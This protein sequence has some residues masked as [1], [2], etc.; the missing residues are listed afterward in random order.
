MLQDHTF[1]RLWFR[2]FHYKKT[3]A[4][5]KVVFNQQK[6]FAVRRG[7]AEM[8]QRP[9]D[10]PRNIYTDKLSSYIYMVERSISSIHLKFET[11][12]SNRTAV[13][14]NW[15]ISTSYAPF[16][17]SPT[18]HDFPRYLKDSARTKKFTDR[19]IKRTK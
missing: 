6:N 9:Y 16:I 5:R 19:T 12:P 15:F 10:H 2:L 13:F 8:V 1:I 3:Q 11:M 14:N 4:L 18:S 7:Y 17:S